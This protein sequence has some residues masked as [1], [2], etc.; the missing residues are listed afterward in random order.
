[1]A[2]KTPLLS[3]PCF[4]FFLHAYFNVFDCCFIFG[5][6]ILK[7]PAEQTGSV[8]SGVCLCVCEE[9]DIAREMEM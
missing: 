6:W 3:F 2:G 1:M 9:R 4:S 5:F 8:L 7:C